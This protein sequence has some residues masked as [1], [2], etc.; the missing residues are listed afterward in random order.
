MQAETEDKRQRKSDQPIGPACQQHRQARIF[1][2]A[3]RVGADDLDAIEEL[4]R[5]RD[6]QEEDR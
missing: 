6:T 2:T 1:E 4:K 5:R 3:Q